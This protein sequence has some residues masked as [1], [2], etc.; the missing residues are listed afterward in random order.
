[1]TPNE[2]ELKEI[3]ILL[4]YH[5]QYLSLAKQAE[6]QLGHLN[7]VLI[8]VCAAAIAF[9]VQ[10]GFDKS[11]LFIGVIIIVVGFYGILAT[12]KFLRAYIK[13]YKRSDICSD[14]LSQYSNK[15][16]IERIKNEGENYALGKFKLISK[17]STLRMYQSIY[18]VIIILGFV[19]IFLS[20]V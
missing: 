14:L 4:H 11:G 13:Q 9:I 7:N 20:I 1:M 17:I 8:P 5:G 18:L 15:I 3:E 16:D 19:S 6:T 10:Q 12:T 2:T